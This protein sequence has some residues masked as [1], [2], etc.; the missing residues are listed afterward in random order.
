MLMMLL[1]VC[2]G[3]NVIVEGQE[4]P[5]GINDELQTGDYTIQVAAFRDVVNAKNVKLNIDEKFH[6]KPGY[7]VYLFHNNT[8]PLIRVFVGSFN[9][10]EVAEKYLNSLQTMGFEGYIRCVPK[11]SSENVVISVPVEP[12]S[13]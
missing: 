1:L 11:V 12:S 7:Q 8:D 9:R 3:C 13:L 10:K 2:S 5:N 6:G 4:G